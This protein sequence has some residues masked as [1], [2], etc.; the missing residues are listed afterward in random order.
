MFLLRSS[1]TIGLSLLAGTTHPFT[2][3]EWFDLVVNY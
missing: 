2:I 1:L 3:V